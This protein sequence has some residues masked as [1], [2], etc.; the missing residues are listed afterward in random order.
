MVECG[1]EVPTLVREGGGIVLDHIHRCREVFSKVGAGVVC[2]AKESL[3]HRGEYL[4]HLLGVLRH[5]EF[6]AIHFELG[7]G[8]LNLKVGGEDRL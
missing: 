4:A 1:S 7:C 2:P 6:D 5:R 3:T 8:E